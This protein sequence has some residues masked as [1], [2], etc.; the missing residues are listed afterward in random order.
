MAAFVASRGLLD[1]GRHAVRETDWKGKLAREWPHRYPAL[2][3]TNR[4]QPPTA[5]CCTHCRGRA[6]IRRVQLHNCESFPANI[7]ENKADRQFCQ[8]KKLLKMSSY[9]T[10]LKLIEIGEVPV[11]RQLYPFSIASPRISLRQRWAAVGPLTCQLPLPICLSHSVPSVVKET[12]RRYEG[13]HDGLAVLSSSRL[14]SRSI[15]DNADESGRT[16]SL[17]VKVAVPMSGCSRQRLRLA[18]TAAS[19]CSRRRLVQW[20]SIHPNSYGRLRLLR[21]RQD[22]YSPGVHTKFAPGQSVRP[23]ARPRNAHPPLLGIRSR[24][25]ELY[26]CKGRMPVTTTNTLAIDIQDNIILYYIQK[27]TFNKFAYVNLS[28]FV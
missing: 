6:R 2:V 21:P 8:R 15:P 7:S 25:G 19:G 13:C 11:H 18:A 28:T 16:P 14:A 9:A 12:A 26:D 24:G 10:Y 20:K 3:Y 4:K 17:R 1:D 23:R 27:V 22:C 5:W